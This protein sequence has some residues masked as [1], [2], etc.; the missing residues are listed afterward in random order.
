VEGLALLNSPDRTTLFAPG[1]SEVSHTVGPT[2]SEYTAL[3]E[4]NVFVRGNPASGGA[5]TNEAPADLTEGYVLIGCFENDGE[6]E[7]WL[8]HRTSRDQQILRVGQ[9][10]QVA[11][12][13][14]KILAVGLDFVDVEIAN[15]KHRLE[16]GR[17]L[18]QLLDLPEASTAT[19][20]KSQPL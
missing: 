10:V 18:K 20:E 19:P 15:R 6:R 17:N 9:E 4:H 1:K 13:T 12:K 5:R 8:Y 16:L 11:G 2:R 14:L 7:G 3:T